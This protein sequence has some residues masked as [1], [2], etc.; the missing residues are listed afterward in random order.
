MPTN[1]NPAA[2]LGLFQVRNVLPLFVLFLFQFYFYF[3][4]VFIGNCFAAP[5]YYE[6]LWPVAAYPVV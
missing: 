4:E 5:V 6:V 1:L 2:F 3:A